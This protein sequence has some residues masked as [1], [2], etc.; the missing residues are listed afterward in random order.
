MGR[1]LRSSRLAAIGAVVVSVLAAT[2]GLSAHRLDEYLQAARVAIDPARVEI[3]LDLTPGVAVA[4]RLIAEIDRN[5]DGAI[6]DSEG[7][8]YA[9]RVLEDVRAEIDGRPIALSLADRR[10][11]AV[12]DIEQGVGA[13]NLRLAAELPPL[14]P[15]SHR[16]V[17][18]NS[19]HSDIGAYLAN[20]LVPA[21]WRVAVLSQDRDYTQSELTV[22]Y[23]LRDG[24]GTGAQ[25]WVLGVG[26][27]LL[28]GGVLTLTRR[29]L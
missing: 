3:Q 24:V 12:L 11:P 25:P 13:I 19:H 5:H 23:V 10:M 18:R 21:T 20:A 14:A 28:L 1:E 2:T 17:I 7:L 9:L 8:A 29:K 27:S 16:L 15:G 6:A 4:Q 22:E 26:G